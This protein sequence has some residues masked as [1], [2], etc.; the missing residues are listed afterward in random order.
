LKGVRLPERVVN[1]AKKLRMEGDSYREIAAKLNINSPSSL[2][3]HLK[4]IPKGRKEGPTII[5][6]P[7]DRGQ[8]K[9]EEK[10]D[11]AGTR[12]E[13][14]ETKPIV[15]A[16]LELARAQQRVLEELKAEREEGGM[17]TPTGASDR[18]TFERRMAIEDRV[19]K[20]EKRVA[21]E[22]KDEF[23]GFMALKEQVDGLRA[24]VLG[25]SMRK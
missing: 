1:E 10:A 11:R 25:L 7:V 24:M 12:G 22:R 16:V 2:Q 13:G 3:P 6:V 17:H 5:E 23:E 4:G 20:L 19:D 8:G 14:D 15:E 9:A 18:F 21:A